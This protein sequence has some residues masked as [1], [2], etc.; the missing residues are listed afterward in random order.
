MKLYIHPMSSNAQRTVDLVDFLGLDCE[1]VV[2]DLQS[3]EQRRPEFLALNPNG[4]VP[5]LVD[6]D[7]VIWESHAILH[8]LAEKHAPELLGAGPVARARVQQW[9]S[10]NLAHLAPHMSALAFERRLKAMFGMGEPDPERVAKEEKGMTQC[11]ALMEQ[12]LSEKDWIAGERSIADFS[13][14]SSVGNKLAGHNLDAYP[15]VLRWMDRQKA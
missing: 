13:L 5:V 15:A 10:F 8:Y 2:V 6:E 9:L 11:L 12:V 4:R 3:G 7:T 1:K 14:A